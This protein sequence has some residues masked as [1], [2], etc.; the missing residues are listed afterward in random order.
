MKFDEVKPCRKCK[1]F[2]TDDDTWERIAHLF[3]YHQAHAVSC[4]PAVM[5]DSR[6]DTATKARVMSYYMFASVGL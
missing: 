3:R 1:R 5:L 2:V 4:L 6:L